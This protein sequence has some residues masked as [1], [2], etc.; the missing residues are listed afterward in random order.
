MRLRSSHWM[1]MVLAALMT[2]P[3]SAAFAHG[4]GHGGGGGG[5]H[6]GGGHGGG[7]GGGHG[8]GHGG[9]F[10]GVAMAVDS[11]VVDIMVADTIS[12]TTTGA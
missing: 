12:V 1:A 10:G 11:T 2:L 4:G 7:F 8:G 3:T 6:G 9:G 5:G